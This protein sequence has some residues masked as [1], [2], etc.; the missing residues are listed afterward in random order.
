MIGMSELDLP[1]EL[2]HPF[3]AKVQDQ[4]DVTADRINL[5]PNIATRL[6]YPKQTLAVTVPIRMDN[7]QVKVFMG[8]RIQ[9]NDTLGPC[10]GGIRYSPHVASGEVAALAMLMTWKCALVGLPLGGGKGGV[11]CD[12]QG[13]SRNELQKIT[14]R[15]TTALGDFIGPDRDIPAPDMGTNEQ[16]MAWLMDTYS[17]NHGRMTPSVVTGKPVEIGGS[18]GRREATG[19]GVVTC[20][21]KAAE[22]IGLKIGA[23]TRVIVQGLGNVGGVAAKLLEAMGC[24]VVGLCDIGGAVVNPHGLSV[25]SVLDHVSQRRKLDGFSGGDIITADDF[26]ALPCD[27][28]ILAACENQVTLDIAKKLQCRLII[29]GANSPVTTEADVFLQESRPEIFI[30]PD[31]LAN[32]GGVTVSY[33]EWVQGLQNFFWSEAEVNAQLEKI[34][35]RAFDE[36]FR[37]ATKHGFSMRTAALATGIEKVANAMLLRGFYP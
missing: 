27:I 11:C 29:E 28:L 13:L 7:Q 14:R 15:F 18:L 2:N 8:Y 25:Q 19:R 34:M 35:V 31:I 4:F 9:H 24:S 5:D 37:A 21:L 16:T 36:I 33:F 23:G 26:F 10:K 1:A 12:P 32:A 6:R 22:K 20:A 17:Q 3:Y 30:V